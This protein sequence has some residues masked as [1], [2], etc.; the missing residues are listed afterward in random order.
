MIKFR[1]IIFPAEFRAIINIFVL[2]RVSRNSRTEICDNPTLF[3]S[4]IL[5]INAPPHYEYANAISVSIS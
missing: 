1:D 3:A 4:P 2:F 5:I